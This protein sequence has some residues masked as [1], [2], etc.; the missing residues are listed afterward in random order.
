MLRSWCQRRNVI[1]P[2]KQL[3]ISASR[4]LSRDSLLNDIVYLMFYLMLHLTLE[5]NIYGNKDKLSAPWRAA[6]ISLE[7]W[8]SASS[9]WIT[10]LSNGITFFTFTAWAD[11]EWVM[12]KF[13]TGT[14]K[15]IKSGREVFPQLC[16]EFLH[17]LWRCSHPLSWAC[18]S[19]TA[20]LT[21]NLLGI[22]KVFFPKSVKLFHQIHSFS[23]SYRL[24]AFKWEKMSAKNATLHMYSLSCVICRWS[25]AP[26]D[27]LCLKKIHSLI[28]EINEVPQGFSLTQP[29]H[30]IVE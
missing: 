15:V 13:N 26:F 10:A 30:V 6:F 19:T 8:M 21:T 11:H 14:E 3:N 29:V 18:R 27:L 5:S 16:D 20:S 1:S 22:E 24:S 23:S 4:F 28:P 7:A 25:A 12:H 17:I 2:I 9:L